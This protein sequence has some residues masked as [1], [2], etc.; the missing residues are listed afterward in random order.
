MPGM[1][2]RPDELSFPAPRHPIVG[3][4]EP[5]KAFRS[6]GNLTCTEPGG[7]ADN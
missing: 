3:S 2:D 6:P 5:G 1:I 4:L 7:R